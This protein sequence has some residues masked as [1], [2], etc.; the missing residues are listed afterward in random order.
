MKS[1]IFTGTL[2]HNRYWPVRHD[3]SYPIYLYAFDLQEFQELSKRY[4]LFGYNRSGVTSIY[5]KDYIEHSNIPI[6]DKLSELLKQHQITQAVNTAIMITSAR[7]F[8]YVFNPVNFYYCFGAGSHLLA[9]VAEVNNTYG[10]RHPYVLK[11]HVS[12]AGNWFATFKTPKV[13]HVSPFNKVEGDYLFYF[14]KPKHH[15]EI[16]I[17]LINGDKKILTAMFKGNGRPMTPANHLKTIFK[18]PFAPHLSIPRIYAHAFKLFFQKKLTFNDKPIPQSPMTLKKQNPG[19]VESICKRLIFKALKKISVGCLKIEMPN[20]EIVHFGP[21]GDQPAAIMKIQDYHFFPR[22][23]F[24]GEIGFGEGYMYQEWDSPDLL[25]L[26]KILIENRDYV[27]DGNLMLSMLTRLKEKIAHDKRWNSI[28]NTPENIREHYDLSNAFYEL[29]L[30]QQMLYSCGI[31][32]HKKDSL[33]NAQQRK[34]ARILTQADI[35]SDHHI[36]EIGCGWGG[37][38]VFAAKKTGCR[39]TGITVSKAQYERACQRV[40]AEGL[41]DRITIQRQDYRHTT[42]TFDRIVSIEMIEAVGPQF[43]AAYF[44][45]GQALLKPGGKMVFQ[46]IIIEDDRYKDYCKERD[47]IQKHIFPGGHLP[48]LKILKETIS[49]HTTFKILDIHHMGAHYATTLAHWRARFL[50]SKN[51]ISNLGFDETFCRKWLYYFSICEAGFTIGGID[52]I[53]VTMER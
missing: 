45:Q 6:K 15:L 41:E 33:E 29:F 52:D 44:K 7:Y 48:C 43:F 13:F 11:P 8:N 30:D 42:G 14:S 1:Q 18:H 28:K 32:E 35:R 16:K 17:E 23:I 36:L 4:P 39:V 9:I 19:L 37:F 50:A 53:Q 10:E 25:N 2:K 21:P 12:N 27:S 46:A 22:I 38:A 26:L 49:T 5:D 20:Q 51:E 3:L 34:M 24:D 47:W 31:F 40:K